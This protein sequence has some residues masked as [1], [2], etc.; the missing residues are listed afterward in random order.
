MVE[1]S[2]RTLADPETSPRQ[3]LVLPKSTNEPV[4][5]APEKKKLSAVGNESNVIGNAFSF[6][7]RSDP[8]ESRY[9]SDEE[10]VRGDIKMPFSEDEARQLFDEKAAIS[11]QK[12]KYARQEVPEPEGDNDTPAEFT[13]A[14]EGPEPSRELGGKSLSSLMRPNFFSRMSTQHE[15]GP[16]RTDSNTEDRRGRSIFTI[17]RKKNRDKDRRPEA[18]DDVEEANE[19]DEDYEAGERAHGLINSLSLGGPAINLL[20]SCLCEDEYGIARAPLLLNLLGLKV[21]DVSHSPLTK[22]RKFRIELEYGVSPQRMKWFVEKTA[23]DLLY[24]HSRFKLQALRG[25]FKSVDLPRYPVPP[26][27]RRDR[28][29]ILHATTKRFSNPPQA[30]SERTTQTAAQLLLSGD[31]QLLL[32]ADNQLLLHADNQSITSGQSFRDRLSTL[33]AHFS[34]GSSVSSLSEASPELLRSRIQ[35]N[36]GYVQEIEKYLNDLVQLVGMRPQSNRLFQFFEISPVSSLLSYETGFIGKQGVIHVGG[37]AKSQGWRVGHFKANDL[38]GMIDRRS[39]KWLLVRS[40]YVMYVADIIATTPL[41]VFI[42]DPSFKIHFRGDRPEKRDLRGSDS[43][44]DYDEEI[45]QSRIQGDDKKVTHVQDKVFKHLRIILENNERKLV[46]IPKSRTE[47]KLWLQSLNE[48]IKNNPWAQK[49]RFGSFAPVRKNCFAQWFVDGRDYFWALSSALE[50]AKDV[51]FIHDWWL[52][53]ELYLRRPA[54]GNQQFRIDRILQRKAQQGVKIFVIVYRNVGTTIPIDSLYT[55]HSI[56]SLNQENIHVI[57]SPNQLLQNTYFWAHHEKI[58]VVDYNVAFLG[59]IDLCYGRY[60]TPDHVISDDSNIDF[61]NLDPESLTNEEF[62]KFR[63]FPGKDYSNTRVKDFNNLDKPYEGLYD[64]NIVPR[65]PWHDVHMVTSGEAAR[66]LSRHFVQRWN[67]LLRQKRPSRYTPLLTPPPDLTTEMM[68]NLKL[69]GTCD[70]QLLRS[71]GN[72]SLGLKQHE[73]S[74]YQAYLKLIEES[75]HFVYIEN[76]FFVTSCFI[77]GTEI[78]NRIGDALVDRIIRAHNEGATWKAIIIIPLVPGFESLVDQP[79][80][81]SVRVVM[82]C[83]YLSISRGASSLFAKLRKVGIDPDNYIQFFSLRKWGIM[84]PDRNLTTE[85]LYIHAKIMVV[86]DRFAI[87]GSANINERSMRG[88]RDS[89]VAAVIRDRET[90][91]STMNGRPYTVSKFA[92]TLRLRLMREHLGVAVDFLDLVERKFEKFEKF[93]KTPDGLKAETSNLTKLS[94]RSLSAA[95]ELASRFVLQE[96]EGTSRWKRYCKANGLESKVFDIPD[97]FKYEDVPEPAALPLS[98]NNRTGPHEANV[99]IREKKKHS[100]D[101]R[102]QLS[103]NHKRDVYGKGVDKYRTKLAHIARQDSKKFL[104]KL[105]HEFMEAIPDKAFLPD[106][107]NVIEF[108]NEEDCFNQEKLDEVTEERISARN[109][110]RWMLLKKIA[111]LQLAAAKHAQQTE[112][113]RLKRVAIGLPATIYDGQE[114]TTPSGTELDST[115]QLDGEYNITSAVK[116]THPKTESRRES[117]DETE[118]LDKDA[119]E[120]PAPDPNT[121]QIPIVTLDDSTFRDTIRLVNLPGVENFSKFIDPYLFDDPLDP[122]FYEDIWFENARRNTDLFRLVFHAQPDDQVPSWKEYKRFMKL[123]KAFK[124]AQNAEADA[125]NEARFNNQSETLDGELSSSRPRHR[126]MGSQATINMGN[127]TNEGGIL[128]DIPSADNSQSDLHKQN[129][130][131]RRFKVDDSIV[132]REESEDEADPQ[133]NGGVLVEV[134]EEQVQD[135]TEDGTPREDAD[136]VRSYGSAEG[137]AQSSENI[138]QATSGVR[139]ASTR[140]RRAGT[141]SAR[142]KAHAGDKIFDRD[143]AQRLLQEIHGHLV[144]FPVDWLMRELEGGNWFFNTDRI[145]PIEIYD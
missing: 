92:H 128:G 19:P 91:K 107:E 16:P 139:G 20:A 22:N 36:Q 75:E 95:V 25:L 53:P 65:M 74:I 28:M 54:N 97:D 58:C 117:T 70:L 10:E 123:E 2:A 86:D 98:F 68:E 84:G 116:I 78:K 55:K 100:Y 138:P 125:R 71:A 140:K 83:E 69:D 143:S 48:M 121:E 9:S 13:D 41:E 96:F 77:D 67:Y 34:S 94:N 17:F 93:A 79:D 145:P 14:V 43:E 141:F 5:A 112:A 106:V 103:D 12:P 136:T 137:T 60:D 61:D 38:K 32:H 129:G 90:I 44:S 126:R 104:R 7:R 120:A 15:V 130:S 87:I 26:L 85:Q 3:P 52:S 113:E 64:R 39:E 114:L 76:Q 105:A 37:T 1:A 49:H 99:G 40:S 63:T 66:D 109:R 6:F 119:A 110:E 118:V 45:V 101:T 81:S 133:E 82:Q 51:I 142:R 8:R 35:S 46:I 18:I 72:W 57:R 24:L 30:S 50:M 89:E 21:S 108:L 127:Y 59:G 144:L 31:N 131:R 80:G 56:L 134:E 115:P 122:D 33:R 88:I 73:D 11:E 62:L 124:L 135:S 27:L 132:E 4:P 42:V 102:V 111:Y 23:K 47:Q 29:S